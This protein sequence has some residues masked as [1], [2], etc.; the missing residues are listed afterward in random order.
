MLGV[1]AGIAPGPLLTLVITHTLRYGLRAGMQVS[2]APFITDPPIV[3]LCAWV[4]S[5]AMAAALLP[6]LSI[7]G[8]LFVI[9][10]GVGTI[11]ASTALGGASAPAPHPLR[12]GIVVNALSPHPYLFW[13]TVGGPLVV[14]FDAAAP[15][16]GVAFVAVFLSLVVAGKIV[17]AMVVERSR[18]WLEGRG[19]RWL[20][21]AMGMMLVI[22]GAWLIVDGSYQ[23]S[24]HQSR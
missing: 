9:A 18:G 2:A 1:P 5:G 24:A 22:M 17:L 10:L 7:G 14:R 15:G 19:Y 13:I 16:G 11:R 12:D 6:W 4:L 8:G 20:L 21:I 3:V 23:W